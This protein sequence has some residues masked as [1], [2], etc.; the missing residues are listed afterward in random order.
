MPVGIDMILPRL[1][2]ASI[3]ALISCTASSNSLSGSFGSPNVGG[4][5]GSSVDDTKARLLRDFMC[6]TRKAL[7]GLAKK[8]KDAVVH[9]IP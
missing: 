2:L 7:A 1:L 8:M 9:A 4:R 6:L 5:C 3:S